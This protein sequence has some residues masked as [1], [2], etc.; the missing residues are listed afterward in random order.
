MPGEE[1]R[2]ETVFAGVINQ[3]QLDE[4]SLNSDDDVVENNHSSSFFLSPKYS[5]LT[6]ICGGEVF[7][8]H[9][10][11]VCPRSGYFARACDGEFK[12]ASTRTIELINQQPILIR[13]VLEYLYMGDYTTGNRDLESCRL[14]LDSEQGLEEELLDREEWIAEDFRE[15]RDIAQA[16]SAEHAPN[17]A[18]SEESRTAPRGGPLCV[19]PSTPQDAVA[20]GSD[21]ITAL[22]SGMQTLHISCFHTL[23]Y[24]T[25]DY[26][27]IEGLKS[28]AMKHFRASFLKEADRESFA[29]A[30]TKVYSLTIEND[31]GLR[32]IVMELTMDNLQA[33][34]KGT[35]PILDNDILKQIPD[36]MHDLCVATLDKYIES[37][38][39]LDYKFRPGKP[40]YTGF[41]SNGRP[42]GFGSVQ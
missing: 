6:I 34:R 17:K 7:S 16:S 9:R 28:K 2:G 21:L 8:A 3:G 23:M 1:L 13:K 4:I 15:A 5:D 11:V 14:M 22:P 39:R 30:V 26:F 31:R 10:A 42:R 32:D 38:K 35:R 27:Q 36:F 29:D 19:S 18:V 41:G 12:E 40:V 24:S 33:L 20:A 25:A 37:K